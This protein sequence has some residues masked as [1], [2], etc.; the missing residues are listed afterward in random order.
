[1]RK[2]TFKRGV[3]LLISLVLL[4]G[5][6]YTGVPTFA[7]EVKSE[8]VESLEPSG[9]NDDQDSQ[10]SSLPPGPELPKGDTGDPAG[11]ANPLSTEDPS[12]VGEPAVKKD[13]AIE[14]DS[15]VPEESKSPEDPAVDDKAGEVTEPSSS[16]ETQDKDSDV[17][18]DGANAPKD[19]ETPPSDTT[20][21]EPDESQMD[22]KAPDQEP[23][24]IP[25]EDPPAKDDFVPENPDH[26][27]APDDSPYAGKIRYDIYPATPFAFS[28]PMRSSRAGSK[29]N[30]SPHPTEPGEVMLFKQ[31]TPV[32]GMV[33]VWDITLRIEGKDKPVTSDII[34][35][36]DTSGSMSGT[37]ITKA[38]QA[39]NKFI[40]TLLPSDVTRI[41]IVNFDFYAHDVQALTNN[42]TL[43]KAGIS[44]LQAN[45]GTF[46]QAGVKQ[47]E[48]MLANSTADCKHIVLLSDGEPTYSYALNNPDNFLIPIP[49]SNDK[50]TGTHAPK[51]AYTTTRVGSGNSLRT[52]YDSE[53]GHW[54]GWT[55]V[56]GYD[57]YYNHGNSAIAEAGFAKNSGYRVWTIALEVN[58]TGQG[59]LQ[60]MASPNSYYTASAADLEQVFATIAGEIG[61]A[62]KEATITDPMGTGFQIPF[63]EVSNMTSIPATPQPVYDPVAK[64]ITWSPGTLTTELPGDSTIKYAELKYRV[65]LNDDI[66][67][68]TPDE[69]EEYPTNGN[70]KIEYK[71]ANGNSLTQ[72]FPVPRVNPVLYKVVK[73]L[74]DKDGNVITADRNFTIDITGPWGKN[75][76]VGTKSFTL[77]TSTQSSTKLLTDLRWAQSYTF[78]E[79]GTNV[80]S[81]AD[82]EIKYY[83]NGDEQTG[84]THSFTIVDGNTEDVEVKVVNKEKP[85]TLTITKV[86]DQ[87]VVQSPAKRNGTKAAVSFSF[88]VTGPDAY[89]ASFNLPDTEGSWTKQ[90]TGLAKGAYTV[91]ETTTGWTT[92]Y[93]VNDEPATS[94]P[95]VVTID[96]GALNQTVTVTNKQTV[97]MTVT[98]NKNW[99]SN[100]PTDKPDIWFQLLRVNPDNSTTSI[101]LPRLVPALNEVTWNQTDDDVNAADFVRYAPNGNEY[102]YKV[103]EV[104]ADGHDY[105]PA[106]YSKLE[107]G[108]QVTNT[109]HPIDPT[110][111]TS[112]R[113]EKTWAGVPAGVTPPTITVQVKANGEVYRTGNLTYPDTV[114]EWKNLPLNG[115]G[116]TP[117]VY[118]VEELPINNFEEGDPTYTESSI[119]AVH[120]TPHQSQTQWP[121]QN[122][123]FV[124]TRLTVGGNEGAFVVWTLNH[125]P[126]DQ[127][128]PFLWNVINNGPDEMPLKKLKQY[129]N[130]GG[131]YFLWYEGATVN[132]DVIPGDPNKG[133]IT[134]NITFNDDGTINTSTLTFQGESTWT[135]FAVGGYSS[136][137]AKITNTYKASG[138]WT[139]EVTKVLT[140]RDLVAGEFSFTLTGNEQNQTKTNAANGSVTFDAIPFTQD[141]IGK[142]YTYT[143]SE[144]KGNLGGV[145][146]DNKVVTVSVAVDVDNSGNLQFSPTYSPED[147]TFN[148]SYAADDADATL[149]GTKELTG[150]TL[151]DGEFTFELYAS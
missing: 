126:S 44:G 136:K 45:G 147:T 109:F 142:T 19:N 2:R 122:P 21:A 55:W 100:A 33:N 69:N 138:S 52:K 97:N 12:S 123:T 51:T 68:Q 11:D 57:K 76:E 128:I 84:V 31:A 17:S 77:N 113:F 89:L 73:V 64:R 86:L 47:A 99:S 141:D 75:A 82:Y 131:D 111:I 145:T 7:G 61:A 22:D 27:K 139:P 83:V 134:I 48:A 114:L 18:P 118:T 115:E 102:V 34:L 101:G 148:N 58:A 81:L 140:G 62:V 124:I 6:T 135:H 29:A 108:L 104:D 1:M 149:S 120:C 110:N 50:Q 15:P 10:K 9:L 105:V 43:L 35:V 130:S 119:E 60:Q 96:I 71:D 38:K 4:F 25:P 40:D 107:S 88:T 92:T 46:T 133:E 144:V 54:E 137:L 143:I 129:L 41:G 56:P 112:L 42:V 20:P 14:K 150:R 125:V 16:G 127:R 70:A 30:G 67:T 93:Q 8:P 79:T 32:D 53:P 78:D 116:G 106:G 24:K 72:S 94:E 13:P 49:G 66:L 37:R 63:G 39:A 146:Y 23:Q 80:G 36:M 28:S 3:A 26:L 98:A 117:I 5:M 151:A 87:S 59:I 91:T 90:L 121:L 74:Q 95:A 132:E 103:Q 65:E 85:G